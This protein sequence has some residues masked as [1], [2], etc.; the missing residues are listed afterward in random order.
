M[1]IILWDRTNQTVITHG[2]KALT[3][4]NST[5]ADVFLARVAQTRKSDKT[6]VT[7]DKLTVQ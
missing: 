3:F 4:K 7:I 6:P 1:T 2:G 5:D